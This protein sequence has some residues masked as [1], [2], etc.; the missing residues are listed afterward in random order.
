MVIS[1]CV[2]S[3]FKDFCLA[4]YVQDLVVNIELS[5]WEDAST[6][7][8]KKVIKTENL[9]CPFYEFDFNGMVDNPSGDNFSL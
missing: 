8:A 2:L 3:A 1:G 9:K 7:K 5:T 6:F 4:N